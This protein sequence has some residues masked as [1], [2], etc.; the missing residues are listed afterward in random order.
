MNDCRL[1]R[2]LLSVFKLRIGLSIMLYALAGM[3]S[4]PGAGLASWQVVIVAVAV[5][6]SAA[7]AGAFNQ[8]VERDL[9]VLPTRARAMANFH[10]SLVQFS[11]LL[12]VAIADPLLLDP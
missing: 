8:Y 5:L 11:L 12:T 2:D 9:V 7:S 3:A 1:V 4:M 10:G 6:L